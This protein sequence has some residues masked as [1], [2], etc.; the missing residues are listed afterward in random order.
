MCTTWG[1][2][3]RGG[4]GKYDI[5]HQGQRQESTLLY[6]LFLWP[7]DSHPCRS[8]F[9]PRA[10]LIACLLCVCVCVLVC[11]YSHMQ[12]MS[13]IL[14]TP[15]HFS[16]IQL[17]VTLWTVTLPRFLCPWDSPGKNTGS[18]LPFPTPGALSNPG[19]KPASPALAGEFFTTSTTW[20]A[21]L[22]T[23]PSGNAPF[24]T[25]S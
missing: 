16:H 8:Q 11:I 17:F 15:S 23:G 1:G 21:P 12:C 24:S 7:P 9:Y 6:F 25:L 13:I 5:Q 14:C 19:I 4:C 3:E 20:E 10:F 18:G 2:T 22:T